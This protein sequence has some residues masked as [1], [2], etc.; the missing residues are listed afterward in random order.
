MPCYTSI[1][2]L[3]P[4][5]R[6][7]LQLVR[8]QNRVSSSPTNVTFH[9]HVILNYISISI[10]IYVCIYHLIYLS[11]FSYYFHPLKNNF[12]YEL[13]KCHSI[14]QLQVPIYNYLYK[15]NPLYIEINSIMLLLTIISNSD[16]PNSMLCPI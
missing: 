6:A 10:Y 2:I 12:N 11:T 14:Y 13:I 16:I 5:G 9:F 7:T 1:Q 4:N 15:I 8:G 3:C